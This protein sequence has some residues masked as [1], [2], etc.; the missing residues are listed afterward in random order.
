MSSDAANGRRTGSIRER[1]DRLQVRLYAGR[2]PVTGK[3]VYLTATIKGTDKAARKRA[4][5]KLSEFRAQILKQRNAPTS[6]TM[7]YAVDEWL[8]TTEVE[9]STRDGYVNYVE[10]YIRP[11][12]GPIAVRKLDAHALESFYTELR[13]CRVRCDRKHFIERHAKDDEHGDP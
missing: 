8:R 2:D 11:T 4:D 9:D 1:G 13:R 10:R 7:S 5:D 12:L 3:D 6:V